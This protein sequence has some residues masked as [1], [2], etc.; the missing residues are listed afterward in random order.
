MLYHEAMGYSTVL[1]QESKPSCWSV[2]VRVSLSREETNELFLSGDSMLAWP[3]EGLVHTSDSEVVP[4]RSGMF[5]SEVAAHDSGLVIRY[6]EKSQAEKAEAL[7]RKQLED[8]G[9]KQEA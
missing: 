6:D 4:E 1:K 2:S 9:I 5:V 3:S 7:L 8:A